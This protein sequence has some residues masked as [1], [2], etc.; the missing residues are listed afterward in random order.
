MLIG[1]LV[2]KTR[3]YKEH[4]AKAST[5]GKVSCAMIRQAF[6]PEA[7]LVMCLRKRKQDKKTRI[8]LSK[9]F[10]QNLYGKCEILFGSVVYQPLYRPSTCPAEGSRD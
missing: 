9:T 4:V 5:P 2:F 10:F 3:D 6:K 7:L 8:V 1:K